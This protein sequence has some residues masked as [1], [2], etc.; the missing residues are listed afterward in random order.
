MI[1]A[2]NFVIFRKCLKRV[3]NSKYMIYLNVGYICYILSPLD[4]NSRT[5]KAG[6]RM[7]WQISCDEELQCIRFEFYTHLQL[8]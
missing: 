5:N 2:N 1:I 8:I 4:L 6:Q 3:L 7:Y